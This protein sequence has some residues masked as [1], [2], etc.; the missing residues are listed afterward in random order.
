M[1]IKTFEAALSCASLNDMTDHIEHAV[2][3]ALRAHLRSL[4]AAVAELN[5]QGPDA[6]TLRSLIGQIGVATVAQTDFESKVFF[7]QLRAI[8]RARFGEGA[9]PPRD[10]PSLEDCR[11]KLRE[12]HDQVRALLDALRT[13]TAGHPHLREAAAAMTAELDRNT[14]L[15]EDGLFPRGLGLEPRF[16]LH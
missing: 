9:W 15:E 1:A 12:E 6:V 2:H 16:G 10:A 8:E 5:P 4:E 11:N 3:P 7:P 14:Y 13:Q